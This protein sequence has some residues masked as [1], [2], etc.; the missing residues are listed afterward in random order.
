MLSVTFIC[1]S[2]SRYAVLFSL[3]L[4]WLPSLSQAATLPYRVCNPGS[5][6][7]LSQSDA[8]CIPWAPGHPPSNAS[9]TTPSANDDDLPEMRGQRMPYH[10]THSSMGLVFYDYDYR[11]TL[12][13]EREVL[14]ELIAQAAISVATSISHN[15]AL[16]NTRIQQ[17]ETFWQHEDEGVAL[18]IGPP[19]PEITWG[20]LQ[21]VFP[22]LSGWASEWKGIEC[23]WEIWVWP[24]TPATTRKLGIGHF[25]FM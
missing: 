17:T 23:D 18:A 6:Q 1:R 14:E 3:L 8:P 5:G 2:W 12:G 7:T 16:A 21:S 20:E 11:Y 13:I 15:P 25:V 10:M 19:M 4:S 24:G 22:L 9:L